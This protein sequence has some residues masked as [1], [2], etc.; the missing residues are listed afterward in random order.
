MLGLPSTPPRRQTA[1]SS[2]ASPSTRI[3][4]RDSTAACCR[5]PPSSMRGMKPRSASVP[6]QSAPAPE[7]CPQKAVRHQ[8]CRHRPIRRDPD[9]GFPSEHLERGAATCHNDASRRER[10]HTRRHR[11][12]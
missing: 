11:P 7:R 9:L 4:R 6:F 2:C 1:P 5:D 3:G 8:R 12:P 10:R